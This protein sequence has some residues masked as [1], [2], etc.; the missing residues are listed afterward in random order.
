MPSVGKKGVAFFCPGDG[1]SFPP[2]NQPP[3]KLLL[4]AGERHREVDERDERGD[5]GR[6]VGEQVPRARI[7]EST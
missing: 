1:R 7:A 4:E 6:Q 3:K 2:P 5:V